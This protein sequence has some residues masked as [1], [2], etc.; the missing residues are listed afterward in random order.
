M[1]RALDTLA[2]ATFL[3]S[4]AAFPVCVVAVVWG[5]R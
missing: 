1:N 2:W 4:A 5:S 3:A